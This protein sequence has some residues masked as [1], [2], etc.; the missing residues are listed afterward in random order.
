[1]D[2]MQTL[3]APLWIPQLLPYFPPI[4]PHFPPIFRPAG[5]SRGHSS[6]IRENMGKWR[7]MGEIGNLNLEN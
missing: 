7:E 3:Q 5:T 6:E 2:C 4:F 1:M